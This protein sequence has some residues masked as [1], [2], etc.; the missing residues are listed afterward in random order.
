MK[1]AMAAVMAAGMAFSLMGCGA[2]ETSGNNKSQIVLITDGSEKSVQDSSYNESVYNGIS[3]YA[4]GH[5]KSYAY[6]IPETETTEAYLSSID[7]AAANGAEII[8]CPGSAFEEAIYQAQTDHPNTAFILFDG[9]PHDADFN[10]SQSGNVHTVL[11]QEEQAGYL[12]GYGTVMDGYTKLG[13]AGGKQVPSVVRY[14]YGFIQGADAAAEKLNVNISIK[15]TYTNSFLPTD[16][17]TTEMEAWYKDGTEV[18]FSCGGMMYQSVFQAA[19]DMHAKVIGV[20]ADQSKISD[21]VLTSAVKNLGS[22]SQ[23][24]LSDFYDNDK[25]WPKTDAGTLTVVGA[26]DDAV[27]LPTADGTWKFAEFT[28]DEYNALYTGMKDGKLVISN[29]V[30]VQPTVSDNTS[31]D[32]DA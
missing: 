17:L 15:Y 1:K 13:F 21:T 32:Y 14:G 2:N 12:A 9:T 3:E 20:D 27:G 29:E 30:D 28:V 24:L 7:Q 4:V 11:F 31:V 19:E 16:D 18:I 8:V 22:I 25:A 26:N 5:N 10:Y 23:S 6:I